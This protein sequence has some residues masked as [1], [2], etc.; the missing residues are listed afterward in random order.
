MIM[1]YGVDVYDTILSTENENIWKLVLDNS[2]NYCNTD[3]HEL[4]LD[5]ID[6]RKNGCINFILSHHQ[7]FDLNEYHTGQ[8]ALIRSLS[9]TNYAFIEELLIYD[10]ECELN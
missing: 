8:I 9:N 4:I 5:P 6:N 1:D 2:N 7:H 3:L 10:I